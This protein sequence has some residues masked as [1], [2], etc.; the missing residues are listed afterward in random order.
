MA[1]IDLLFESTLLLA[2]LCFSLSLFVLSR[3]VTNKL[4][5]S[6]AA[7]TLNVSVWA[8]SFFVSRVL[9]WRFFESV[10]F[11]ATLL[12]P[13]LS[14]HTLGLLL[15][16]QD[17]FFRLL[18]VISWAVPAVLIPLVTF[19]LDRYPVIR[20]MS[21]YSPSLVTV[22]SIHLFF[23]GAGAR[24][25]TRRKLL[26]LGGAFVTLICVLDRIPWMGRT[27]PAIG[28]VLLACYFYF[29]K[30]LVLEQK[31]VNTRRVAGRF[32]SQLASALAIGAVYVLIANWVRQDQLL[33]VLNSFLAAFLGVMMVDPLRALFSFFFQKFFFTEAT[34]LEGVVRE[35][36]KEI[37]GAFH[38]RA[39]ADAT[40]R[41]LQRSLGVSLQGFYV[42]DAFGKE[43]QRVAGGTASA[44][45]RL[46]ASFPLVQYWQEQKAWK[47]AMAVE[48]DVEGSRTTLSSRAAAL[49]TMLE[50]L[51][52]LDATLALP[53]V[54]DQ[55]VL[56]FALA[57][58]EEPPDPW[59]ESWGALVFLRPY[60]ERAGE[61]LHE[62]DKYAQLHERD[63]LA[64][65]GE[66]SAGLAHEIRNPLGAIKGAVQVIEPKSDD[67]N[68]PFLKIIVEEVDRLNRVV[69]QFLQYAKPYQ[70]QF[71]F[72]QL[73]PALAVLV[74][75]FRDRLKRE[76]AVM[77]VD[78]SC[79][80]ALPALRCQPDL[81]EQVLHNLLENAYTAVRAKKG[82]NSPAISVRVDHTI[83]DDQIEVALVVADN[84]V[85][86]EK[87][88]LEKIFIPFFTA[89]PQGTG[90]GLSICQK[91]A[92]AH[93]GRMEA[94]SVLGEGT[95]VTL[96]FTSPKEA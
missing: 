6:Y 72:V 26:I 81:I 41:L 89:A 35:A 12:I 51:Q 38:E 39:I 48:L 90:L 37:A 46:P 29:I 20:D 70:G 21:Y 79:D 93:G 67:P 61:A 56:G 53:L 8:F 2:G 42:L 23:A 58:A 28:N 95:Q 19:G 63:R 31:L 50:S 55:S 65:I 16:P 85:G 30:D 92:Q 1:A 76:G 62:L 87:S 96:R 47:P 32:L 78:F 4:N 52:S 77:Q 11:I 27:V 83:R 13:G 18:K 45:Q 10:H 60:F 3:G 43:F 88:N 25:V 73:A 22:A 59:G 34:R 68:A 49:Q 14:L 80:P 86:I 66:M 7:L 33:Y 84:G 5:L 24:V 9:S 75:R 36:G 74:Q 15:L 17:R 94:S 64:L 44:P 69:T 71:R 40:D 54:H 82:Q 91:I 57:S